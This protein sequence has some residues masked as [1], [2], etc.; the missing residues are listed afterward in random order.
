MLNL[1][2]VR[3]NGDRNKIIELTKRKIKMQPGGDNLK[4]NIS[5]QLIFIIL[6]RLG[7]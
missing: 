5:F 3:K 7:N 4:I 2:V 1:R 6:K